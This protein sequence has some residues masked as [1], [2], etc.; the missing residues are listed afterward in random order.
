MGTS[1]PSIMAAPDQALLHDY[2]R[3]Y[4][5]TV[6]DSTRAMLRLK[7]LYRAPWHH[8]CRQKVYFAEHRME[9]LSRLTERGALSG[10]NATSIL[11]RSMSANHAAQHR[12]SSGAWPIEPLT[13]RLGAQSHRSL[14]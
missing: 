3:A 7:A 9:W 2:S 10:P 1:A 6:D 5:S 8:P 4:L 14:S 12:C 13:V 11:R